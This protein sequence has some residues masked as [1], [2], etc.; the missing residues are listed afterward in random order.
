MS[1]RLKK[2]HNVE[3]D[4]KVTLKR[5]KVKLEQKIEIF[6]EFM[7]T[8]E[9]LVG[10]TIFKG[11]PIGQWAIQIRNS[12]NRMNNG[13]DDKVK[14]SL[15]KEKLEKLKSEYVEFLEALTK[16]Y[17]LQFYHFYDFFCDKI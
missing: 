11:Y 12:L 2:P 1:I 8:E 7:K 6:E 3:T 13:K 5:R 14:I 17:P 15:T 10:N 4:Q 16:K 9:K